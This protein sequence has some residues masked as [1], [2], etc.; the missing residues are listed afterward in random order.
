MPEFAWRAVEASGR[1]ARG[2]I[3]AASA[4]QAMLRLKS[5]GLVPLAVEPVDSVAAAAAGPAPVPAKPARMAWGGDKPVNRRD[6]LSLTH[7]LSV[8]T[9]AGLPLA[10]ALRVLIDMNTKPAV[11]ALLKQVLDDV[12]GGAPLSRALTRHAGLFG[13]FYISMVR[14]GEASGQLS[15]MLERLS[16]QI[17]RLAALRDSVVSAATYPAILLVVS[18][19]S[20]V[21]MVG[22]VVP[23]FE[24][25]FADMGDAL[26]L[27]TRMVLA[28]SHHARDWGYAWGLLLVLAVW[29]VA[30]WARTP[31]GST[32]LQALLLRVPLIGPLV[33]RYQVAIFART[34]GTLVGGGV[35]LMAALNIAVDTVSSTPVRTAMG[36]MMVPVKSGVRLAQAMEQT[37]QFEP[38]ALNLVRVGEETGRLGPMLTELATLTDQ[39]I[40]T[41]IKRLLTLLEPALIATLGVLIAGIIV[42]ILLG[43]LSLNELAV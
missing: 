11:Q 23:Q 36:G 38:L 17:A 29:G 21:G 33:H 6:V 15:Q 35:P 40:E 9:R 26:P 41:G 4:D 28:L 42:S 24:K 8:M 5:Q 20:L 1:T 14:A 37:R 3:E 25:L 30:R 31:D 22:F 34:L 13:P 32:R 16:E 43:I 18:L 19:L 12:K 39:R 10:Y 2:Q 7:E 27:P